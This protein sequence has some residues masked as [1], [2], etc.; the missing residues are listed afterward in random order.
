[1]ER[2]CGEGR[3]KGGSRNRGECVLRGDIL[4]G[5]GGIPVEAVDQEGRPPIA[6]R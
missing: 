3:T 6:P 5:G 2:A 1:M 4:K